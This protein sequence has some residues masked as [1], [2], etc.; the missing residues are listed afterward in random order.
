MSFQDLIQENHVK[1][2]DLL[3]I[4]TE[5]YDYEIIK[6]IDFHEIKPH[7]I[8]FEHRINAEVMSRD[9]FRECMNYLYA[10]GYFVMMTYSDAVAYLP[11]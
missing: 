9:E 10:N 11:D 2:I 8:H 1:K 7:I 3:Q 6:M 5:G 4:D